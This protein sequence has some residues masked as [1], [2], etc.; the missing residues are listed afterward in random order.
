MFLKIN[1]AVKRIGL[2]LNDAKT[3]VMLANKRGHLPIIISI[4]NYNSDVNT[5]FNN[6]GINIIPGIIR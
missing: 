6:L 4:A 1:A 3:K 5:E 2:L